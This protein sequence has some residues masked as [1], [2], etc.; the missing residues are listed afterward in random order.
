MHNISKQISTELP[1][2]EMLPNEGSVDVLNLRSVERKVGH[3]NIKLKQDGNE[4]NYSY[5][6]L[7]MLTSR[8]LGRLKEHCRGKMSSASVKLIK[9]SMAKCQK[10]SITITVTP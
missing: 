2:K 4:K 3:Q 7:L 5:L 6:Y 9:I 8:K 10:S 1:Y